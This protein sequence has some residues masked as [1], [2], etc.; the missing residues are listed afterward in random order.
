MSEQPPQFFCEP[1]KLTQDWIEKVR[2][3][4]EYAFVKPQ[5]ASWTLFDDHHNPVIDSVEEGYV[6]QEGVLVSTYVDIYQAGKYK[7][8]TNNFQGKRRSLT[9]MIKPYFVLI[10]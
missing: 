10:T 6:T 1:S 4:V 7:I 8:E 5:E 9:V 2:V 3:D